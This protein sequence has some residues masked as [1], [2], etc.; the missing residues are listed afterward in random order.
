M[1]FKNPISQSA[2][3]HVHLRALCDI[4][5]AAE[6]ADHVGAKAASE[7]L[8]G[9][10]H[11]AEAR[12]NLGAWTEQRYL[13]LS[14]C[15]LPYRQIVELGAGFSPRGIDFA[16]RGVRY[17]ETDLAD[18]VAAKKATVEW[19]AARTPGAGPVLPVPE[20]CAVD[21]R[22]LDGLFAFRSGYF[23]RQK[24][25]IINEGLLVYLAREDKQNLARGIH[26]YLS[27][28]LGGGVWI[29][30]DVNTWRQ[31]EI[32]QKLASGF[33]GNVAKAT[34]QRLQDIYFES[35][36]EAH[37]LFSDA[38]FNIK[39][40]PRAKL[41]STDDL[42]SPTGGELVRELLELGQIWILSV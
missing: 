41:I 29:M 37:D 11:L 6:I 28:R 4:P 18:I 36:E 15:A 10:E 39:K 3:L 2:Y 8:V 20:F 27:G 19:V 13:A 1:A 26:R 33:I 23:D 16:Q 22:D 14:K 12:C 34:R 21:A 9:S 5:F 31:E 24:L 17:L 42:R 7:R 25:A 38:G 32:L 35:F 30:A 40:I